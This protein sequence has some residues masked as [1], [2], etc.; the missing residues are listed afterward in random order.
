MSYAKKGNLRK[1]LPDIIKF[2]WQDRLQLLKNIIL[3]LEII[4][5]SDLTH[6]NG[7]ILISV[8]YEIFIIDLGLCRPINDLQNSDEIDNEIYGVLPYMAPEILRREPYT[9]ASDIY[10]ERPGID[11]NTPQCYIDLMTKC[12]DPDPF[13]RP[14]IR[15]I[16]SKI[17]E[18]IKC[19]NEYYRTNRDGD[20]KLNVPN[21]DHK[22]R[23]DMS[24]F[25]KVNDDSVQ[26]Q[27]NISIV[28]SHPQAYY[29]SRKLT[30]I[31]FKDDSDDLKYMI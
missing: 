13:N 21:I 29:T 31:L 17:S 4:Y 16:E 27:T 30:G 9:Q 8:N 24:E 15:E 28:Q 14:T 7:N 25:I 1:C 20:Y 10:S 5:K 19:I 3:G 11:K 12:W 6:G 18:W 22:L 26:E 23:N 2:K